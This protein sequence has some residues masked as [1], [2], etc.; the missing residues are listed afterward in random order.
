MIVHAG[1]FAGFKNISVRV[2]DHGSISMDRFGSFVQ[3]DEAEAMGL[4]LIQA[5]AISK[6]RK[7][8][9]D[10]KALAA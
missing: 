8:L 6:E 5:A 1:P 3:P 2:G 4:A 7:R 9:E 10:I